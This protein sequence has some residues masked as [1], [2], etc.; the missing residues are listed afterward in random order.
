MN[1]DGSTLEW[2]GIGYWGLLF[3]SCFA[4]FLRHNSALWIHGVATSI[5][6]YFGLKY[7]PLELPSAGNING[8][9]FLIGPLLYVVSYAILR[10][11]YK[12]ELGMEPDIEAYT[13]FS[14]RDSRGLNG[15]DYIVFI[16]PNVLCIGTSLILA[17]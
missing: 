6:F 4:G 13:G 14:S 9:G 12:K 2:I 17:N 15:G 8:A 11:A 16:V 5:L 3:A 7:L 10:V 1:L